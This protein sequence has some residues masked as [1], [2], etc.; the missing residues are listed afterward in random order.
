MQTRWVLLLLTQVRSIFWI[1]LRI[2]RQNFEASG[3][4]DL[5]VDRIETLLLLRIDSPG[6]VITREFFS[7]KMT[8][9][10]VEWKTNLLLR[11]L[12]WL[13]AEIA[14]TQGGHQ[15]KLIQVQ[16]TEVVFG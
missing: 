15:R 8:D 7:K 13:L 14:V 10:G 1:Q 11:L 4:R 2:E 12:R 5:F 6:L 9:A 3:I 16:G